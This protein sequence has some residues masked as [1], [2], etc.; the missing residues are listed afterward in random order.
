MPVSSLHHVRNITDERGGDL[1]VEQVAHGVDE[2]ALPGPPTERLVQL[3]GHKAKIEALLERMSPHP[4]ESLRKSLGIAM[5]ASRADLR[6]ASDRVPGG[7]S[8]LDRRNLG[9][10]VL[11]SKEGPLRVSRFAAFLPELRSALVFAEDAQ[12]IER[13]VLLSR[14]DELEAD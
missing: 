4:A 14:P 12:M 13:K 11:L 3:V 7:V 1:L 10:G 2:N 5:L 9:H 6:A 8:P